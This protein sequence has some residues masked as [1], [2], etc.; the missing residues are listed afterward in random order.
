LVKWLRE[1]EVDETGSELCQVASS[2]ITSAE[3]SSLA[4]K[5]SRDMTLGIVSFGTDGEAEEHG[6]CPGART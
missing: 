2:G 5:W 1:S 4:G 6:K 3:P